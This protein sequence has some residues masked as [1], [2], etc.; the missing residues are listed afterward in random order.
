MQNAVSFFAHD[1]LLSGK[2]A[3]CIAPIK[4]D[5]SKQWIKKIAFHVFVCPTMSSLVYGSPAFSAS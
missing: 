1:D 4:W 2:K 3:Q 5:F